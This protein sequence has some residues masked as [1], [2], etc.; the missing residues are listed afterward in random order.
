M[1]RE[2]KQRLA[3]V[4]LYE[5]TQDA[6]F[7]CRRCGI[8]RPTLRKWWRRY[9]ADG[10]SGLHSRSRRPHHFPNQKVFADQEQWIRQLRTQRRLGPRRIQVELERHHDCHLSLATIHKTLKRLGMNRLQRKRWRR[11]TKR[12]Q[13][14]VPG[15]RVQIDTC[16]IAPRRIQYTAIDD[17]TRL[18]VIKVYPARTAENAVRFLD[19]LGRQMPF[20]I[21]RIQTDRGSEFTSYKFQ[22]ALCQHHI[23]WRP[24]KPRT[25]HLNGKVERVQKTALDEFYATLELDQLDDQQLAEEVQSWQAFY[26]GKRLHSAIGSPPVAK[27]QA[28]RM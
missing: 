4:Q 7:V 22:D 26:N 17:C 6:G 19:D 12:Y 2:T 5:R 9:Q 14:Q 20:P 23:K 11:K 10:V 18:M 8:S 28:R 16:K 25:P 24:I 27:L 3:W 21:Q 15:E 1:D 13:K